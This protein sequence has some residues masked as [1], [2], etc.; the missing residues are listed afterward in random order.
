[1]IGGAA[2]ASVDIVTQG[3]RRQT[4]IRAIAADA[5]AIPTGLIQ[6]TTEQAGRGDTGLRVGRTEVVGRA[7]AVDAL[8]G[9][10]GAAA[11][12]VDVVTQCGTEFASIRFRSLVNALIFAAYL[13]G[14]AAE[15]ARLGLTHHR[16]RNLT[17]VFGRRA[18]GYA[19]PALTLEVPGADHEPGPGEANL[20]I[21]QAEA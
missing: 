6:T 8:L 20:S 4:H 10:V 3:F 7:D 18:S 1:M 21:E 5:P 9:V 13:I 16:I 12:T 19:S 17:R 14:G 15:E 2:F 11:R